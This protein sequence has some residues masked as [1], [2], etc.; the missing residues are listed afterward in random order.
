MSE[1]SKRQRRVATQIQEILSELLL[2][3]AKDPRI[4]GVTIMDVDI[5]RELQYATVYVTSLDGPEYQNEIL[6]SLDRAKGFLRRELGKQISI[7]HTPDLRFRWDDSQERAQRINDL[8]DS[9]DI[10]SADD[11]E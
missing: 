5:D 3:E 2:F 9:L 7:Q 1:P 4:V 11:E 10:Q 8:L 6:D